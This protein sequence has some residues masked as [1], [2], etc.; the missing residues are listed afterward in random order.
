MFNSKIICKIYT[1]FILTSCQMIRRCIRSSI[2]DEVI[3]SENYFLKY[4]KFSCFKSKCCC[5]YSDSFQK[6]W[7][8]SLNR[9][10]ILKLIVLYKILIN[11]SSY[12]SI[13]KHNSW[14]FENYWHTYRYWRY[15]LFKRLKFSKN[16]LKQIIDLIKWILS[17]FQ[18]NGFW[19]FSI[20]IS[21]IKLNF[22]RLSILTD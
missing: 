9:I 3:E 19:V 14:E 22:Y 17:F 6:S 2:I 18:S 7:G 1:V 20:K 11:Y 16:T 8:K 13:N 15:S 10:I 4:C 12:K 5:S 21:I